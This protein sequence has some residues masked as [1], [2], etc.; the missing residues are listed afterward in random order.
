MLVLERLQGLV[1]IDQ[2]QR[3]PELFKALRD[4]RLDALYAVYPGTR[5][6][7][8]AQKVEAVPLAELAGK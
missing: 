6:Y 1:V 8:L 7:A 3:A 2:V 5:R 4:L